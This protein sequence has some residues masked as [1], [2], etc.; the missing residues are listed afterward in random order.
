MK[1]LI[2]LISS[3]CLVLASGYAQDVSGR[4]DEAGSSYK[5]GDLQG[6]RFA[7]QQALNEIDLAI[8]AEILKMLPD[9]MGNMSA[10]EGDENYS[11]ASMGYA[12]LFVSRS[13]KQDDLI[14]SSIQIIADSPLLSGLNALLAIPM[15][16]SDPNQ[17]RIRVSGYRALL[18]RN[19]SDDGKVSWE[20]QI[21]VRSTLITFQCSGIEAEKTVTDMAATIPVEQIA[22]FLQ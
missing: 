3:V 19:Q 2:V 14:N 20:V 8:G 17:K 16:A 9:K 7:L 22:K 10:I 21:P 18:N 11:A 5:G 4:L 12:G 15:F 1:K 6:T 13:Y